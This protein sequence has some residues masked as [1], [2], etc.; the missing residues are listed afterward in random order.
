MIVE[1][2]TARGSGLSAR[3]PRL[4]TVY[5]SWIPDNL[6]PACEARWLAQLCTEKREAIKRLQ[7]AKGRAASLL[8]L[9]LLKHGMRAYGYGDF[10]LAAVR[11][12][13]GGK[14]CCALPID[15]NITHSKELVACALSSTGSIGI[16]TEN[17]R[18]IDID[19]FGRFLSADEYA[20]VDGDR[21]RFFELWTQKEAVVKAHG[22]GGIVNLRKV[23]VWQG[24]GILGSQIWWLHPLDIHPDYVTHVA[25]AA[26]SPIGIE[27]VEFSNRPLS[28]TASID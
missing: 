10:D 15:F 20:R 26:D 12:P 4:V 24:Q 25:T 27:Y 19:S 18:P 2:E 5:Y 13:R 22:D 17:L 7:L 8:G 9:R 23:S 6:A 16:D 28:G 3:G 11:F 21:R 1:A 14:P